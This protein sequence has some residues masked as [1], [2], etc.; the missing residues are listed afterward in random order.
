MVELAR[1][2]A[3]QYAEIIR[4]GGHE[5]LAENPPRV[6]AAT[7][8][9]RFV[10]QC[11]FFTL[12]GGVVGGAQHASF[13]FVGAIAAVAGIAGTTMVSEVPAT[14]KYSET[15]VRIRSGLLSPWAVVV[16]RALPYPLAGFA[17]AVTAMLLVAP[18]TGHA[19][20][21]AALLP[22][23]P[24]YLLMAFTTT[25]T[26]L[27]AA[28]LALGRRADVTAGN[29]AMSLVLVAG[30]VFIPPDRV[31]LLS[32]IGWAVPVRHGLDAVR[33]ALAGQPWMMDALR[34]AAVGLGWL[35]MAYAAL[36]L[37]VWRAARHGHDA[38][39]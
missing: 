25:A 7:M 17:G 32:A 5:F 23:L 16:L 26:G 27:A 15:F 39:G 2:R 4:F 37:Q 11:L 30:G 3:R 38:F 12:L 19:S 8:L 10:L 33:A 29:L 6:L 9:P 18:A 13:A 22:L 31:P 14:D 21:A 36:R 35:A 28:M 24:L 34:E 20:L 1:I